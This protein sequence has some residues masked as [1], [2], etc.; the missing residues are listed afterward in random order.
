MSGAPDLKSGFLE[1]HFTSVHVL[2][3]LLGH[4]ADVNTGSWHVLLM[5]MEIKRRMTMMTEFVCLHLG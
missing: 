2:K 4:N 1:T 3:I 5:L